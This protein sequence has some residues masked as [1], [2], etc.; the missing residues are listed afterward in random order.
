MSIKYYTPL[1]FQKLRSGSL[2]QKSVFDCFARK[3][4]DPHNR[5]LIYIYDNIA[6]YNRR[7]VASRSG[8]RW[9]RQRLR[10]YI[11]IYIQVY[12]IQ[13]T[14]ISRAL[15]HLRSHQFYDRNY[16]QYYYARPTP[17]ICPLT[18]HPPRTQNNPFL[19]PQT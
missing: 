13:C 16:T 7:S 3:Y 9:S 11:Y 17:I 12:S 14:W 6:V 19:N 18:R 8:A 10:Y 2:T 1:Y 5:Y 4:Y 15:D